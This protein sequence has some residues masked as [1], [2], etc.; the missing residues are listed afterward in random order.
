M[1]IIIVVQP[2]SGVPVYRQIIEQI[3]FQ[4]AGGVVRPGDE[5]PSTRALSSHLGVNPMTVSKAYASLEQDGVLVRRPGKPLLVADRDQETVIESRR[6]QVRVALAPAVTR[7]RQLGLDDETVLNIF[8]ELIKE[9]KDE[10]A[11]S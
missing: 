8:R 1:G 7:I 4:I 3:R 10:E 9:A 6:E 5:L 11:I 2:Q